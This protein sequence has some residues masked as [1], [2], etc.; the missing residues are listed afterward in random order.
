[1]VLNEKEKALVVRGLEIMVGLSKL[2]SAEIHSIRVPNLQGLG[3]CRNDMD[4]L[5]KRIKTEKK[6]AVQ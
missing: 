5:I 1:M 2:N 3:L 6:P 4:A